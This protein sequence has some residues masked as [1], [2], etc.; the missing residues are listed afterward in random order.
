MEAQWNPANAVEKELVAALEAGESKRFAEVV[1]SAPLYLPILPAQGTEQRRELNEYLPLGRMH[2]LAFTAREGLA[3][4]LEPFSMGHR[5]ISAA[6]LMQHW[7]HPDYVLALNFD[8]PIGVIMAPDSL[9]RMAA[10][11]EFLL[12]A[13]DAEAVLQ[14]QIRHRCLADL[15]GDPG[16]AGPANELEAALAEA[17]ARQDFE[18]YLAALID[19]D[20][21]LPLTA[22]ISEDGEFP[23]LLT[24]PALPA[25]TSEE[26][27]RRTAPG[28]EHFTR[29]PFLVLAAN[30]PAERPALCLNPGSSTELI[31]GAEVLDEIL[32]GAADALAEVTETG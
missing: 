1:L 30:W 7:P 18:A 2:V 25:F 15:G 6:A 31:S 10:G 12:P 29:L 32:A 22:P 17:I 9:T 19:A 23:W 26:L 14:A 21:L 28:I 3:R 5:E 16:G 24:G 8:L 13:E 20:V 11:E 4:V 27:L